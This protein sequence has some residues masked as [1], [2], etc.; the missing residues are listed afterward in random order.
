MSETGL[1]ET[2]VTI[3]AEGRDKGKMYKL[4]EMPASK[5]ERWERR[6]IACMVQTGIEIPENMEGAGFGYIFAVGVK[7]LLGMSGPE[8]DALHDELM[9]CVSFFPDPVK[10]PTDRP[11]VD[12]DIME[13]KTILTL[14]DAVIQL[15]TGFSIA[16]HLTRMWEAAEVRVKATLATL[17]SVPPSET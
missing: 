9:S 15:H 11:L 10:N 7:A 5:V 8:V 12:S 3:T 16:S 14:K 2:T 6:A 13:V 17:T 1:K 4:T